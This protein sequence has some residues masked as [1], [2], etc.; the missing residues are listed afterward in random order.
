VPPSA[1][2]VQRAR[3]AQQH[4]V[5]M[6]ALTKPQRT[7]IKRRAYNNLY[8]SEMKT[9][10]KRVR[11][12]PCLLAR[13]SSAAGVCAVPRVSDAGEPL[14]SVQSCRAVMDRRPT[15]PWPPLQVIEAVAEGNYA[16]ASMRLNKAQSIIDKNV[17][18]NVI[19]KN[20]AARRKSLLTMKVK[21]LEAGAVPAAAPAAAAPA[22]APAAAEPPA[23]S[24]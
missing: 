14:G 12:M 20:T 6:I 2:P 13:A 8:K 22:A 7:N 18:R 3:T 19:H 1:L 24:A 4:T 15:H 16:Y 11:G 10:I 17:S 23:E 21:G 5:S 9:A